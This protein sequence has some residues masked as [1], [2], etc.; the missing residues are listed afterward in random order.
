MAVLRKYLE[1]AR[2]PAPVSRRLR[3][4]AFDPSLAQRLE[5]SAFNEI[6]IDLP[7]EPLAAG[8]V[9]DYVEVIDYDP[10]SGVFY[11]PVDL[12]HPNL[13][14][15]DGLGPS[16]SNPQYHQQM[17]YAVAMT[18]IHHFQRALG[19]VALWADR[20][21][22]TDVGQYARQFVRRLRIYPHALRDRNAYYSP[23]RRRCC[24]GISR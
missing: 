4:L 15:Q 8:P 12:D 5:T 10:A 11:H 18:T 23:Q 19:R 7:W 1:A 13:I 22:K 14:A 2:V 24:L 3:I 9:G 6:S 21:I 17:V 16:E 20:R